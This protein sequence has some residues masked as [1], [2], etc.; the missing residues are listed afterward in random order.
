M[1]EKQTWL[2]TVTPCHPM[3]TATSPHTAID[4]FIPHLTYGFLTYISQASMGEA[5]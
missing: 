1:K 3:M 4:I 2:R 5:S